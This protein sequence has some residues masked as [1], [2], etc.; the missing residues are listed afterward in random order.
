MRMTTLVFGLSIVKAEE[1]DAL[2]H[3]LDDYLFRTDRVCRCVRSVEQRRQKLHD[4]LFDCA[5]MII[6]RPA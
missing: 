6:L 5:S 3:Q 2:G 1:E 4:T